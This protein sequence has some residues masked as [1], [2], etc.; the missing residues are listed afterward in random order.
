[1]GNPMWS[2]LEVLQNLSYILTVQ[3]DQKLAV[4]LYEEKSYE[5]LEEYINEKRKEFSDNEWFYYAGMAFE[6]TFN[7]IYEEDGCDAFNAAIGGLTMFEEFIGL[8][9]EENDQERTN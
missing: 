2:Y 3:K 6:R 1:M 5:K 4:K 7:R 9:E 8:E